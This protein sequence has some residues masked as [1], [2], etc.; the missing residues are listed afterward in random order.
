MT[1]LL[2]S[3]RIWWRWRMRRN[4]VHIPGIV[5]F[6]MV[7]TVVALHEGSFSVSNDPDG[8]TYFVLAN[9]WI[10]DVKAGDRVEIEPSSA[11]SRASGRWYGQSFPDWALKRKLNP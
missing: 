2:S 4:Q 7:A 11:S 3:L 8:P 5:E 1:D 9:P 6:R 10:A